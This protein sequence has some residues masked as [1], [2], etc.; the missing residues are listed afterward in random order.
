MMNSIITNKAI[1]VHVVKDGYYLKAFNCRYCGERQSKGG[2]ELTQ[3]KHPICYKCFTKYVNKCINKK[4]APKCKKCEKIFDIKDIESHIIDE[5]LK[6]SVIKLINKKNRKYEDSD[7][8]TESE[9]D[10]NSESDS[11]NSDDEQTDSSSDSESESD[12]DVDSDSSLDYEDKLKQKLKGSNHDPSKNMKEIKIKKRKNDR[13]KGLFYCASTKCNGYI[14]IK[15]KR[16]RKEKHTFK[17]PECKAKN[18]ID[19]QVIHK[20]IKDKKIRKLQCPEYQFLYNNKFLNRWKKFNLKSSM[21]P[22]KA[23]KKNSKMMKAYKVKRGS[24]EWNE[25]IS[26]MQTMNNF[27]IMKIERLQNSRL[28]REYY[29]H[30]K[31]MI[32]KRSMNVNEMNVWHGTR[33]TDPATIWKGNGFDVR[34]ANVGGCIWFAIQNSYSM[35]GYQFMKSNVECQVFL[36]FVSTGDYESVKFIRNGQIL[37]VYKNQ[38]MYPAYLVT[39]HNGQKM[40]GY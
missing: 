23:L 36:A 16:K 2:I 27:N 30:C 5:N 35:G 26:N 24:I 20:Q 9:S 8:E 34:Y 1:Y 17:C 13:K 6:E 25:V 14:R 18:C 19:C 22:L 12:S 4:K 38:T 39:Y 40:F 37:N 15:S 33:Q 21:N 7:N 32:L 11:D 31:Q 29:K 3:C 10:T 28:Y